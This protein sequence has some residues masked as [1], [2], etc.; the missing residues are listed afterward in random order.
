MTFEIGQNY[1]ALQWWWWYGESGSTLNTTR[2]STDWYPRTKVEE[3]TSRLEGFLVD[4]VNRILAERRPGRYDMESGGW[5]IKGKEL[6][7]N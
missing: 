3:E 1:L 2:T 6:S 7:L 4:E 5:R